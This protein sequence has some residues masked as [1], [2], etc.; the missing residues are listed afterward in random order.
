VV[1]KPID[2]KKVRDCRD[3]LTGFADFLAS[4]GDTFYSSR[5][6]RYARELEEARSLCEVRATQKRMRTHLNGTIG[7]IN[8][9]PPF[10]GIPESVVTYQ[11]WRDYM[12]IYYK[13]ARRV[14]L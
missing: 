12:D 4:N 8:D 3:M 7:T 10:K 11:T 6:Y 9:A 14:F 13:D 1:V 2:R 5:F